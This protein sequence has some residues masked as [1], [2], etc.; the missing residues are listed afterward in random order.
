ML[1][2]HWLT[3]LAASAAAYFSIAAAISP[4]IGGEDQ[5]EAPQIQL[6]QR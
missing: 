1:R 5:P 4:L 3:I 6:A 2:R